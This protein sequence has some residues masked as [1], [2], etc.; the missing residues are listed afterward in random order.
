[1]TENRTAIR[2][3]AR[4]LVKSDKMQRTVTVV[5]ERLVRDHRYGKYV[6]RRSTFMAHNPHDSAR[7]GDLVEIESTRPLSRRKRWRVVRVLRKAQAPTLHQQVEGAAG[8][9][10]SEP[11]VTA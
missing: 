9:P 11:E 8:V 2:K 1:M 10:P 4:G 7:Q 5:V 6:R 3:R